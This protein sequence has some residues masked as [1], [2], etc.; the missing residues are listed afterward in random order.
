[1]DHVFAIFL[2]TRDNF[3]FFN[4]IIIFIT[5]MYNNETF[6]IEEKYC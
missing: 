2:S 1:M 6:M 5:T 3:A 4:I